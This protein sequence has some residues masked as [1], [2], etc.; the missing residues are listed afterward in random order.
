ML[1]GIRAALLLA[2]SL[3]IAG[4]TVP[5]V[6]ATTNPIHFLVSAV[7]HGVVEPTIPSVGV[8]CVHDC[9][10]KPSDIAILNAAD[11]V[12]Y[13]DESMEPFIR[14]LESTSKKLV[15]LSDEVDLLQ[16][17]GLS[18]KRNKYAKDLHIWLSPDNAKKITRKVSATLSEIDPENAHMYEKNALEFLK[19]IDLLVE[20]VRSILEPV[21]G[22][23]Y[24]VAHDAYQY[25][26]RFFGLNFVASLN[27]KHTTVKEVAFAKNAAKEQGVRCVFT[28]LSSERDDYTSLGT[29]IKV[30]SLDPVGR[31]ISPLEKDGYCTLMRSLAEGFREC[32]SKEK[33]PRLE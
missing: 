14:K 31:Q 11:V 6:A 18:S 9:V 16:K 33:P 10:L 27:S 13:V 32:L 3:P 20:D 15:R 21:K 30:L 8:S 26:D 12:F 19:K 22:V 4:Y 23:P 29:Q 25:F 1:V 28:D 24:I 7:V 2:S 17:R 5:K